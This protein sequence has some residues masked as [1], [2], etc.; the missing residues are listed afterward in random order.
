MFEKE[1]LIHFGFVGIFVL[2]ITL[3][4]AASFVNFSLYWL[5]PLTLAFSIVYFPFTDNA[6]NF[7]RL[8]FEEKT[9]K[10]F[11][12]SLIIDIP[13][14]I[15]GALPITLCLIS[16]NSE[17]YA[18]L[19]SVFAAIFIGILIGIQICTYLA[20][21]LLHYFETLSTKIKYIF[22]IMVILLSIFL[23][24]NAQLIP[25]S[26]ASSNLNKYYLKTGQCDRISVFKISEQ[27]AQTF[28]CR[29]FHMFDELG[30]AVSPYR[31][32]APNKIEV[33]CYFIY[34]NK[35]TKVPCEGE[36]NPPENLIKILHYNDNPLEDHMLKYG[37]TG[38]ES[39]FEV[40][41]NILTFEII[42][43]MMKECANK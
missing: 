40:C 35:S 21:V 26:V 38:T 34:E 23:I 14:V 17:C 8:S 27:E 4:F 37:L 6:M 19:L 28:G 31:N 42:D 22:T 16:M 13:L 25:N 5:I 7:Y 2:L 29:D 11:K 43:P 15:L 33:K 24:F 32:I 36:Y 41:K 30:N 3:V 12:R 20:I 10:F 18:G 39:Y 9:K 1:K